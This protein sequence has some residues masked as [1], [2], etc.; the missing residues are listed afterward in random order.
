MR[1]TRARVDGMESVEEGRVLHATSMDVQAIVQQRLGRLRGRV[2]RASRI[3]KVRGVGSGT[4]TEFDTGGFFGQV[5]Q[6]EALWNDR[7]QVTLCALYLHVL[8]R[9]TLLRPCVGL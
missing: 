3:L 4:P 1:V 2:R 5:K 7:C 6:K 8:R 9:T